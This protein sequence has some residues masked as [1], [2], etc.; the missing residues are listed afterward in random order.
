MQQA[1]RATRV[2]CFRVPGCRS[3]RGPFAT[4]LGLVTHVVPP[5]EM[6]R[7]DGSGSFMMA[8]LRIED[9]S[10][11]EDK[12]EITFWVSQESVDGSNCDLSLD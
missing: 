3:T 9:G 2:I 7:R 1:D 8:K 10:R 5:H 11:P 6:P 12:T 4:V